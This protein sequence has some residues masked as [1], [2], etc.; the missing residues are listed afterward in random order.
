MAEAEI[1]N[2][3]IYR[4]LLEVRQD[5]KAQNGEVNRHETR[6]AVLE[7]REHDA[8]AQGSKWGAAAGGFAGGL[9]LVLSRLWG[10]QP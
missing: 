10:G 6:L 9:I 3:E 8:R 7:A 5:V 2:G 1:S 4:I